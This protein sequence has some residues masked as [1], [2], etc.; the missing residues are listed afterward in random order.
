MKKMNLERE[1]TASLQYTGKDL[2]IKRIKIKSIK[3]ESNKI[4]F[5]TDSQDDD[6][7]LISCKDVGLFDELFFDDDGCKTTLSDIISEITFDSICIR[8]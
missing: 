4:T 7:K 5:L 3:F 6:M 8:E 2:T 1:R